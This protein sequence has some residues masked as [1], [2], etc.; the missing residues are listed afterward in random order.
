MFFIL[1]QRECSSYWPKGG[2]CE[3]WFVFRVKFLNSVFPPVKK[4]SVNFILYLIFFSP[5]VRAISFLLSSNSTLVKMLFMKYLFISLS[6]PFALKLETL[7]S[8]NWN[9]IP[10]SIHYQFFLLNFLALQQCH[11][12]TFTHFIKFKMQTVKYE[13]FELKIEKW[14]IK[15][16]WKSIK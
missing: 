2:C 14:K 7:F 12:K 16:L 8:S 15:K 1:T 6:P 10:F 9:F 5:Y 4:I 13:Y 3:Y 11:W